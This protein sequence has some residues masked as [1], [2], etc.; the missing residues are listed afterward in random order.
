VLEESAMM[1]QDNAT[2]LHDALGSLKVTVE[3]FGSEP[4]VEASEEYAAAVILLKEVE[5]AMKK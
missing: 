3:H 5:G 1:V 2:R 4:V